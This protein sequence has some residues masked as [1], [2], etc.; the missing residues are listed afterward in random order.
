[1][2]DIESNENPKKAEKRLLKISR[3]M[4]VVLVGVILLLLLFVM[5]VRL[6]YQKFYQ[7]AEVEFT[8]PGFSENFVP[9]G[10]AYSD[11]ADSFIISGYIWGS[12]EARIYIVKP[13]GS[14][15]HVSMTDKDGNTFLSHSG[16]IC[17]YGDYVYIA[18]CDGTCYVF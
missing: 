14:S 15:R 1:M 18:G 7:Q 10:F 5:E 3:I 2:R 8:V 17:L 4:V 16:G 12:N 13:D 11:V 6:S 9:Q